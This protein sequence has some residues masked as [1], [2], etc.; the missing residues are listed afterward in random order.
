[1]TYELWPNIIVVA[2]NEIEMDYRKMN[3]SN[4]A[5]C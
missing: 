1:L 5:N 3:L 4:Q 2:N